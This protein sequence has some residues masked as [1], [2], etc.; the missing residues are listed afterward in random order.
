VRVEPAAGRRHPAQIWRDRLLHAPPIAGRDPVEAFSPDEIE[1][2]AEMAHERFNAERLQRHWHLGERDIPRHT[3]PFLV[4]WRDLEEKWKG[5]DRGGGGSNP[6]GA[7]RGRPMHLPHR[8]L[9]R[10]G[11]LPVRLTR[12]MMCRT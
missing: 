10:R 7:G 8:G 9:K 6:A 11:R 4:P 12:R 1:I 3:S 2:L 5:L